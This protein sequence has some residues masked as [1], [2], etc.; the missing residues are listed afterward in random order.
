MKYKLIALILFSSFIISLPVSGQKEKKKIFLSGTVTDKSGSPIVGAMILI[1]KKNT[2]V[3]TDN[4]GF[5]KVKI[6]PDA[7]KLTIF[8][9]TAG[10][11]DVMIQG[12]TTIDIS[13]DSGQA[14]SQ[15]KNDNMG[16]V[17]VGYGSEEKKDLTNP[18][19]KVELRENKYASYTNIYDMLRGTVPGIQVI[20]KRIAV[21]STSTT[22]Q[23][24]D[25]LFVVDGVIVSSIDNLQPSE[26]KSVEVLKGASASIYGS[27]GANGVILFKLLI[28][29]D[30]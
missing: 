29:P 20:G 25:P 26:I 13:F 2:E 3:V 11:A 30:K 28:G 27:R 18:V 19:N 22:N 21:Q 7:A 24:S 16:S 9:F 23:N 12:R 10:T 1:D 15:T 14:V 6:K 5:Y 8:S 17:N 4:K